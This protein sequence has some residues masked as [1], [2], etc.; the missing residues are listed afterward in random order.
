LD[1][2]FQGIPPPVPFRGPRASG[3]QTWRTI[4]VSSFS[5]HCSPS[6][7]FQTLEAYVGVGR[8][9]LG[10]L[11][12]LSSDGFPPCTGQ[13]GAVSLFFDPSDLFISSFFNLF[14]LPPDRPPSFLIFFVADISKVSFFWLG[15]FREFPECQ[16]FPLEGLLVPKMVGP[17]KAS[18]GFFIPQHGRCN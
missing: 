12:S 3:S 17:E 2:C 6:S 8:H 16:F 1:L 11:S 9:S 14:G 4:F 5:F 10:F 15:A 13:V 18:N 7:D